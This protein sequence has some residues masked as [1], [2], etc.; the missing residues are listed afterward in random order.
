MSIICYKL[1]CYYLIINYLLLYFFY[2]ESKACLFIDSASGQM[3][4]YIGYVLLAVSC[5]IRLVIFYA[6]NLEGII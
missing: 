2:Q 5:A 1:R 4:G 6:S 3:I